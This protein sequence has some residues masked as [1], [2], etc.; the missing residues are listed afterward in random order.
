MT[1]KHKKLP[2][3]GE[4]FDSHLMNDEGRCDSYAHELEHYRPAGFSRIASILRSLAYRLG[5]DRAKP[6]DA[7]IMDWQIKQAESLLTEWARRVSRNPYVWFGPFEHC[8]SVGFQIDHESARE[9]ADFVGEYGEQPKGFSG[10]ALFV[11]DHGNVTAQMF[12]RG[13]MTR[14]LFSVV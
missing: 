4:A 1:R 14:E 5:A 6:D 8:G 10:L 7:E 2:L 13:R 3:I 11:N 9:D 12:S